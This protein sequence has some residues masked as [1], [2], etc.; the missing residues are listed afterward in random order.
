MAGLS[1]GSQD[2]T[3]TMIKSSGKSQA[4][5]SSSSHSSPPAILGKMIRPSAKTRTSA[6]W[7]MSLACSRPATTKAVGIRGASVVTFEG[8]LA[9]DFDLEGWDDTECLGT[10]RCRVESSCECDSGESGGMKLSVKGSIKPG[11]F[12]LE[13]ALEVR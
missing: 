9:F 4:S 11:R 5:S 10:R 3:Y 1:R 13:W 2:V 6:R 7:D 12:L 8:I